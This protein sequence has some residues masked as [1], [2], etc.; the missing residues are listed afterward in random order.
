MNSR[1]MN[2]YMFPVLETVGNN[3]NRPNAQGKAIAFN[4]IAKKWFVISK[5]IVADNE[6]KVPRHQP[7][8]YLFPKFRGS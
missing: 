2:S 6:P 8:I 4:I 5:H 1:D 7:T 3:F